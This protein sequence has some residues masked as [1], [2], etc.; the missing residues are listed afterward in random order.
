[1]SDVIRKAPWFIAIVLK[2]TKFGG[3]TL[4][5]FGIFILGHR[6]S[7]VPLQRHE[8]VHWQQ[9][10]DLGA[11]KFYVKYIWLTLRHGYYN[12]PMEVAARAAER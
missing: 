8:L 9:A 5:P 11:L 1:M 3:V 10:K 6:L 12:N 7:E 4:P 2:W